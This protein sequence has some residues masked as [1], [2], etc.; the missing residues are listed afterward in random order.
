MLIID[1]NKSRLGKTRSEQAE[2]LRR[3]YGGSGGI[4]DENLDKLKHLEKK[5][6]IRKGFIPQADI[7]R[8]VK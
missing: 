3:V 6:G 8:L 1:K 7:D 4:S 5:L 2:N